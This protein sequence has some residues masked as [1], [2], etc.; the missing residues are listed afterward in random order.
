MRVAQVLE[1]LEVTTC[2]LGRT[3]DCNSSRWTMTIGPRE[4]YPESFGEEAARAKEA[5]REDGDG[6]QNANHGTGDVLSH[7]LM[8]R[9]RGPPPAKIHAVST[10]PAIRVLPPIRPASPNTPAASSVMTLEEKQQRQMHSFLRNFLAAGESGR[11][12]QVIDLHQHGIDTGITVTDA[13]LQEVV[14][15][16]PKLRGLNLS[17]CSHITDAGLWAVA[18]H[19]QAQLDTI[20]LAQCEKVT[21][22]GLRLLA[23]NCRLVLVDLSDCPQLNDA[24]LQ[25]LAAG[26]W[27][28]ETFI[29]KRC[30][31]VSDAGIVKIAQCCKDLRHLDVSECSRLGEYGDKA[32]LEIGKCCPKLRVL[33]LFGCQHVHDPGVRAVSKGCPL[34]TTLRLTGCRDVSSDA[35]RVLAQQC[36]QLEV[37]SLSGCIKTTNSDLELLATNCPQLTWLD[38]SGSPNI[39][40][41]GVRAL[42]QNCTSLTY[43]SL[44]GCQRVGDAALSELTSAGTGGLAKSLGELSLADCPRVTENGVDALTI[45]CSNLITLNLTNCKMIGRR[46]LQRL[47]GKLEFVQWATNFFGYEPLP[48]AAEL[49]RRRDLLLLQL[50]SAI[51]I[52][53]AM[54]GCLARGGL[55]QAKLKF[56]ERK[57]LPKIQARVRGFLVRKRIATEKQYQAEDQAARLIARAY[58][59]LQLRRMLVR[60]KRI[61]RIKEH[62]GEAALI[63]QKIFRGYRDRKL[64]AKMRYDMYCE[65]QFQARV[66]TME[67]LAA[68]KLQRA[69]RGHR[70]R[71]DAAMLRSINEAKRLQHEREVRSAAYIQR[72]YRGHKGRKVRA[73]RLAELLHQQQCHQ[74]AIQMQKVFRGHRARRHAVLLRVEVNELRVLNAALTIQRYWRGIRD[75]HLAAVLIGLIKLRA[76]ENEAAHSIQAAYRMHASRGFMKAM[77]LALAAQLR[78]VKAA[79]DIQRLIRGHRGRGEAELRRELQRFRH[80]AKPLFAKDARLQALVNGLNDKVEQLQRK[81]TADESEERALTLELEKTLQI[82][83]K[84]HDSSRITGTP[85]RYLTQYLQVQLADQLRAKRTEIALDGRAFE[86]LTTNLNDAQK[87]LRGV[88]RELEPLTEGVIKKTRENRVKR[89]QDKVRHERRAAV[90]IQKMFRGFRTRAAVREGGN[91]WIRM[92]SPDNGRPYF[93]NGLTGVTRWHRPLAMDIFGDQFAEPMTEAIETPAPAAP[94]SV[95]QPPRSYRSISDRQSTCDDRHQPAP[96]NWYEAFDDK[97]QAPYYF[98]SQT[99]EYQ[100][101]KPDAIDNA[102]FTDSQTSRKRLEWLEEQLQDP[103]GLIATAQVQLPVLGQWERRVDPLTEYVFFYHPPTGVIK[104]SLSP[105]S[106][107][108]SLGDTTMNSRRSAR[109]VG[110]SRSLHWQYRYGYEYD[111]NG[112]LVTS[113]RSQPRPIWTEHTDPGNG[114]TY[115]Y[116]AL[117]NEYRW[118]KPEDFDI[119]Y[120]TFASGRGASTSARKWFEMAHQKANGEGSSALTTRSSKS[121]TLGKKW[122]ELIDPETQ[123]TYYYN[124]VTGE[125]RWSLSPRSARDTSD[126]EDQISLALFAQVKQL[127]DSP[128]PYSSRDQH[129]SWLEAAIAEKDWRKSDAIVQQIFIRE[130]SQVVTERKAREEEENVATTI[131]GLVESDSSAQATSDPTPS[132]WIECRDESSGATYYY[133]QV[134]AETSWSK[135]ATTSSSAYV[136]PGPPLARASQWQEMQDSNGRTY[137]YDLMTGETAWSNPT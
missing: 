26:C 48:N 71:S 21:E 17:G 43:L 89:L 70:G 116:N 137:Y 28:I 66:M 107:H 53:S 132:A 61:R 114:M 95:Q 57:I 101:D 136:E 105:R 83:T 93:Y 52:Q 3:L 117:T 99:K 41:R 45:V 80:Q 60:A 38:I 109:S 1:V 27:M 115:Y 124:E 118:E 127:R 104:A 18:R 33:D 103:E 25:T 16:V 92:V 84:Y 126:T 50:R 5:S 10:A 123:N 120:E 22:L 7:K 98:N 9:P 79:T 62:E 96:C 4:A 59:D 44:A 72:V 15:A 77:K 12:Q 32:L 112:E 100:W 30:R 128:V 91:C 74:G 40:A 35:I 23:H 90:T 31:G 110:T 76:R 46:F 68:T 29:M 13:T 34:L 51:K 133:N 11:F 125:S 113:S 78:R 131:S 106:V 130:Q 8:K 55:W 24:A 64:V 94:N 135:P 65:Q 54:R 39:D 67:N 14:L 129:M 111:A 6:Y 108:A 85:Q 37:L 86:D 121:R 122:V 88:R 87:Q 69:Y 19:C 81:I 119:N 134:T 47:I 73:Q 2:Y 20:Y 42:A 36:T 75:K 102:Y 56:V 82:K 63:F 58:R 49:C 97:V